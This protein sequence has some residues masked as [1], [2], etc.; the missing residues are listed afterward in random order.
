M[1]WAEAHAI[2]DQTAETVASIF[3]TEFVCRY[4]VFTQLHSNQGR[5]LEADLFQGLC[6]LFGIKKTRTTHLHPQS[7][8]QTERMNRTLLDILFKLAK[9]EPRQWDVQLPCAMASY[10]SSCHRKT[11]ETPNQLMLGREVSTP[12]SLL[13]LPPQP[14]G[15]KHPWVKDLQDNF[16]Q[17]HARVVITTRRAH[18]TQKTRV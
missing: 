9:D 13:I 6:D 7:D 5:Q 16:Q 17:V 4:G 3:V 18:R 11:E 1:K 12:V 14:Q 15:E 10:R 8:G 2:P